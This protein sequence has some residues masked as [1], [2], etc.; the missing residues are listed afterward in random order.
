M[1]IALAP[2]PAANKKGVIHFLLPVHFA[3]PANHSFQCCLDRS[4][5]V[6]GKEMLSNIVTPGANSIRIRRIL[7]SQLVQ[8]IMYSEW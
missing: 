6:R 5:L 1:K 4:E 2:F 7:I 3:G 8:S